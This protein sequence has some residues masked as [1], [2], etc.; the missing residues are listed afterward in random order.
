MTTVTINL[1]NNSNSLQNFCFFQQ[2]AQYSSGGQVYA[3]S[4]LGQPLLPYAASGAILSFMITLQT[5]AGVQQQ[6][7]PPQPGQP[8]GQAGAIRAIEP[9]PAGGT[10]IGNTTT[11]TVTPALGL[12]PTTVTAGLK[13]G[14]FR[15]AT[16][17][18]NPT[19]V[20]YNA[21]V[22]MQTLAGGILLS[23]FVTAPPNVALDCTP[24]LKFYVQ[25]GSYIAGTAIDFLTMSTTAALCDATQGFTAFNVS[26][27]IDGTWTIK[28]M[29]STKTSTGEVKLIVVSEFTTAPAPKAPLYG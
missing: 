1:Q 6:I 11:M 21:G 28:S 17:S 25:I 18:F 7:A 23:N 27:N 13:T 2:P 10:P 19:L 24:S 5:Y 12:S 4:L 20:A 26:Y 15:I 9:T 14:A 8:V 29:V 16:A 22:A 3:S